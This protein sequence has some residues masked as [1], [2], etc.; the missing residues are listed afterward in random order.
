MNR[1]LT[2][3]TILCLL[4]VNVMARALPHAANFA[5]IT[6]T[7]L[8]FGAYL[9]RR[10]SLPITLAVL[11]ASDYALLYVNPFGHA[12]LSTIYAPWNVWYGPTQLFVYSSFGISAL[13]G[14]LLRRRRDVSAVIVASLFCSLQFFVITNA[15][16][17][18]TGSYD[19]D[20]GGLYQAWAAGIPFFKGT[21][22]GDLVYTAVFFGA[23]EILL[24]RRAAR[25]APDA[26]SHRTAPTAQ[27]V[28]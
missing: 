7:G 18:V 23:Y 19:R 10:I 14:Q 25:D 12:G 17:W 2:L 9:D 27:S 16:V 22:A 15:A 5:P 6:A 4:G 13:A 11:L 26:S 3:I 24:A 21:L 20:I 1:R 8:F 28:A